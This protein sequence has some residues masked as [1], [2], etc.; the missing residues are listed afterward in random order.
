M[1]PEDQVFM[2]GLSFAGRPRSSK[3]NQITK[4]NTKQTKKVQ[5]VDEKGILCNCLS[6]IRLLKG[7]KKVS[8]AKH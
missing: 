2:D 7:L 4:T 8:H 3:P 1:R 5:P 6:L